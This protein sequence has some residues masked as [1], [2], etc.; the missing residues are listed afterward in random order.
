MKN[1]IIFLCFG[2]LTIFPGA[3]AAASVIIVEPPF[4]PQPPSPHYS[5]TTSASP[6]TGGRTDVIELLPDFTNVA[7]ARVRVSATPNPGYAFSNWTENGETVSS[8]PGFAFT[9][10]RDRNLVA[11]FV[12]RGM[13]H[14]TNYGWDHR[15][16]P[17]GGVV[18][19]VLATA[20]RGAD[21]YVGGAFSWAGGSNIHNLARWDGTRWHDVGGGLNGPVYALLFRGRN[22]YVGGQFTQAGSIPATNIAKWNGNKWE[23]LGP[24]LSGAPNSVIGPAAVLA[25]AA[26]G[27]NLF[28]G[29]GFESAG[30]L[31]VANVA[32]W[33]GSRWSALGDG[34]SDSAGAAS[35]AAVY[36]IAI[37]GPQ[38]YAGGRFDRAGSTETK[39]VALWQRSRWRGLQA[40]V[41]G[42]SPTFQ[43]W[44][45]G[46]PGRVYSLAFVGSTLFVGGEFTE[47]GGTN[48]PGWPPVF[49]YPTNVIYLSNVFVEPVLTIDGPAV[50]FPFPGSTS[51][52]G[53]IP[54]RNFAAWS[55]SSWAATDQFDGTVHKLL[56]VGENL[57]ACGEFNN[58]NGITM[59]RIAKRSS[60]TRG[61][62]L[63]RIDPAVREGLRNLGF[64]S[65]TNPA[66]YW[67]PLSTGFD[68]VPVTMAIQGRSVFAAGDFARAGDVPAISVAKWNGTAWCNLGDPAGNSLFGDPTGATIVANWDGCYVF[69]S[70]SAAGNLP[71]SSATLWDGEQWSGL[72]NGLA[73][74]T[75]P[76]KAAAVA[77]GVYLSGPF[78][79]PGFDLSWPL[80]FWQGLAQWENDQWIGLGASSPRSFRILTSADSA[81]YALAI[82][83]GWNA[84]TTSLEKWDG[85][86][87][88]AIPHPPSPP[89]PPFVW[90]GD[91]PS[92]NY[93]VAAA[94]DNSLYLLT[95]GTSIKKW[96]GS[97]WSTLPGSFST[98]RTTGLFQTPAPAT[99]S[100]MIVHQGQLHVA[101][102]F[103][104]IDGQIITN[105]ARWNGSTWTSVGDAFTSSSDR[106]TS[107]AKSGGTL[108]VAGNFQSIGGQNARHVAKWNGTGWTALGEGLSNGFSEVSSVSL[109]AFGN[110]L[111]VVGNFKVAGGKP[112]QGFAVWT[113]PIEN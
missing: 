7:V 70:F 42:P 56:S 96:D 5:V 102:D 109:A 54:V 72:G 10:E 110:R 63:S 34:V 67:A 45:P 6:E 36:S 108:Y 4:E 104:R 35:N 65:L 82:P 93:E 21:L 80:I 18:G 19:T 77:S 30:E 16:V 24:G 66:A 60:P 69:G 79:I 33:N 95:E 88:T 81:F 22:L 14:G 3:S 49:A 37:R 100:T 87:W 97:G 64:L 38:V 44:N 78:S 101:G 61:G 23:A 53:S 89:P 25:L 41:R 46:D 48:V 39:N 28:V 32:K 58:V 29:G 9:V 71:V 20:V 1:G 13:P 12:E 90:S 84:T 55:G 43:F 74:A 111:Y 31:S 75:L 106:I 94:D 112:S 98:D 27:K 51:F 68:G 91:S 50:P 47:A 85:L 11:N 86:E 107:M 8:V 15:F 83:T 57:Y 26:D 92:P 17:P 105:F 62:V 2:L 113:D 59:S 73:N 76:L 40:G 103:V 52:V 99:I